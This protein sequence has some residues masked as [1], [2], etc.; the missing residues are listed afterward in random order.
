MK[1]TEEEEVWLTLA[2]VCN[3]FHMRCE[4]YVLAVRLHRPDLQVYQACTCMHAH[5]TCVHVAHIVNCE[6]DIRPPYAVNG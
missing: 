6:H 1:H 2:K 3:E 5:F 4:M